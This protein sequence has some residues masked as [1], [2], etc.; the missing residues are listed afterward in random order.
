MNFIRENNG[1]TITFREKTII[2]HTDEKPFLKLGKGLDTYEMDRGAFIINDTVEYKSVVKINSVESIDN[3]YRVSFLSKDKQ[4]GISVFFYAEKNRIIVEFDNPIGEINR[5]W[6][7][8]EG[9]EEEHIYGTG[10]TFTHFDLKGK[11]KVK[12]W[13]AE[14]QNLSRN[15]KKFTTPRTSKFM[16]FEEYESY[17]VQPTFV[18]SDKYYVH[19]DSNAYV[20]FNFGN[21]YN[22][23]ISVRNIPN[24]VIIGVEETFEELLTNLTDLLGR[25]PELPEWMYDG[26]I[27]GL[28][29][30]R[31]VIMEKVEKAQKNGLKIAGLWCQDWQGRRDTG[32]GQ[33]LMWNWKYDE[34]LYPN[35]EETIAELNKKGIKFTGYINTFL[36]VEK[37][38]Y[39]EASEKG[40][41]VKNKE[42]EDYL[43]TTT[44]FDAAMIDL[45]HPGACRWIKDIIIKNM[46][47]I[48]LSGWMA[49]Y[50]EYLPVD[51][52]LYSGEDAKIAHNNWPALWAKV[53]REAIAE[54]GKEGE[55]FFFTRAGHTQTVKY[56]TLMWAGDQHVD[57]SEDDGLPS[58]IP[59]ALSLAMCGFGLTHS[60]IGGYTTLYDLKRTKELFM[61]WAEHSV[62]TPVMRT[63]EGNR[64]TV[65]VQFDYDEEIL[66]FFGK[67]SQ[68]YVKLAPYIKEVVGENANKGIPAMR[69]LFMYYDEKEAY[70]T[71]FEYLLG[72]DLLAAPVIEEAKN[73]WKVYLPEDE[74]VH[75]WTNKEYLAGHIEVEAKLGHTPVFY[76][77]NSK[78]K[79]LFREIGQEF[80]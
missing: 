71:K 16:D 10:E 36:A 3:R 41:I 25:Q 49:D 68:I 52:V 75:L 5:V 24:K 40:Y 20:D 58:V 14:H 69:P 60:D 77:K 80:A 7:N 23:Q 33:Q 51:S 35:L 19:I 4:V 6:L 55:V 22:N 70:E 27:L 67:M 66:Q 45:T 79:E 38:M 48:G 12:V 11:E 1:F 61:R 37:E 32:F 26:V 21:V 17:Y 39:K 76:R 2:T 30:G 56:S 42:G 50:G 54:A 72:R 53:N 47:G 78:Y 59:A 9:K 57:W 46:I 64:P 28:Q 13:V 65:N 74:W 63:H 31:D 62:F 29:G 34:K 44:D 18:S 8:L 73:N 15:E 43:V